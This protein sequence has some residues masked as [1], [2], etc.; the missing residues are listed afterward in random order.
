VCYTNQN[1]PGNREVLVPNLKVSK[2]QPDFGE[3]KSFVWNDVEAGLVHLPSTVNILSLQFLVD[4]VVYPQVDVT[5]PVSL[6]LQTSATISLAV[7]QRQQRIMQH[8]KTVQQ[9]AGFPALLFVHCFQSYNIQHNADMPFNNIVVV[10]IIFTWHH[11]TVASHI[12]IMIKRC[13]DI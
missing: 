8:R 5:P 13:T 7:Q 3:G 2:E 11:L 6:L 1:L 10:I 9:T 4:S 12:N